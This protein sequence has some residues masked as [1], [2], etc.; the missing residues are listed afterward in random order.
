MSEEELSACLH[1]LMGDHRPPRDI[2]AIEFA[3]DI[4]GFETSQNKAQNEALADPKD[5]W[6]W[7]N[8]RKERKMGEK[9]G[10]GTQPFVFILQYTS[11]SSIF[12]L[13]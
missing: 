13:Y 5:A 10:G 3:E 8:G 11:L 1:A 2:T 12:R 6:T 7:V 4:L 9:G